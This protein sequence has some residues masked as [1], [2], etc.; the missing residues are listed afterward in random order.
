MEFNIN[1]YDKITF[2]D[3]N[4][5]HKRIKALLLWFEYEV[6]KKDVALESQIPMMVK[7]IKNLE[8]FEYYEVIPF[9]T[10]KLAEMIDE[11][12]SGKF[13]SMVVIEDKKDDK[14]AVII[15]KD[16]FLIRVKNKI[17]KLW[18]DF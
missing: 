3:D 17:I 4:L 13:N 7:W 18:V 9:F 15:I 16:S 8:S 11:Y 1:K 14:V 5:T 6:Y 10:D 2:S 12:E